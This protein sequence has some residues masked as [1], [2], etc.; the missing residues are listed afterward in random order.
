MTVTAYTGEDISEV[1]RTY[2]D[3]TSLHT[4]QYQYLYASGQLDSATLRRRSTR[5]PRRTFA[6]RATPTTA[7]GNARQ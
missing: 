5:V 2:N 1:E 7:L 6:A 4:E 3:G